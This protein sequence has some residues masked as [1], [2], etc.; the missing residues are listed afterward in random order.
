MNAETLPVILEPKALEANLARDDIFVV[1]LCK[2]EIYAQFH[3]PGAVHLDYASII[4]ADG[5]AMG[6]LPDT[7][8]LSQVF[9]ELGL[10]PDHHVV[11]YDDEGGGKACRLLWT[12]DAI[13]HEN[14]S[15]LNGGLHAWA[16]EQFQ[17]DAQL[18]EVQSSEYP[19]SLDGHAC[20]ETDYILE[21]L[22]AADTSI[23]DCRTIEEFQ[24]TQVRA[25]NGG[26]IP[27]AVNLDW[28]LAM[29]Q[30]QNLRL[31]PADE[32]TQMYADIGITPDKEIIVYCH[33]HHRS[34]HT[35]IVLKS[36]GFKKLRGY[37]GSW[38]DW[39]N[40]PDMPIE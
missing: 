27:G 37:P 34:S 3:V 10:R 19:V 23:L 38:S 9:S 11:A 1:D 8:K 24:G 2:S 32:L 36:L 22:E 33:T 5:Q 20:A 40:K 25:A 28:V 16:G 13:G 21:R 39:G 7:D 4:A 17:V 29:D 15:L 12:L 18:V 14:F 6:L 31:K 35:Y 30:Q 26:H